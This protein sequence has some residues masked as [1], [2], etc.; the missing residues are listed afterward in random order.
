MNGSLL[1]DAFGHHVWATLRL[2]DTC[3]AL[4]PEQLE[5]G[6]P[7]TYG[8]ILETMRHLVGA[9][10]SYLFVPDG[11]TRSG[12]STR[13]RWTC[14]ELRTVMERNGAAWPRSWHGTSYPDAVVVTASRRRVRE[15]RADRASGSRRRCTTA[16][17]TGARSAPPSR[18]SGWSRRRSTSGT[19]RHR[20]GRARRGSTGLLTRLGR[21]PCEAALAGASVQA[22][23]T[24]LNL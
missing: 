16:P 9:D 21:L 13:S 17:T 19:S 10:A 2:I 8:S 20:D 23:V 7:G 22:L 6:V 3:L 1:A 11:R 12:R 15:S 4:N 5:T 24:R 18:R 14:A